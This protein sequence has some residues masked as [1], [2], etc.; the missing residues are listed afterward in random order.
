MERCSASG[1]NLV[2]DLLLMLGCVVLVYYVSRMRYRIVESSPASDRKC[3]LLD[4]VTLIVCVTS[5]TLV[6]F[7]LYNETQRH[8][9]LASHP[10]LNGSCYYSC[11]VPAILKTKLPPFAKN[12]LGRI[13]FVNSRRPSR[14]C[15]A[16][17]FRLPSLNGLLLEN[18][19]LEPS[20]LRSLSAIPHFRSLQ[21]NG[22]ELTIEHVS[23]IGQF[24][25]L[26]DL[27]LSYTN[28]DGNLLRS[29]DTL[30]RLRSV[31]FVGTPL[32]LADLGSPAWKDSVNLLE[33]PRQVKGPEDQLKIDQWS[34]LDLLS[35]SNPSVLVS[36]GTI[37]VEITN[38]PQL[39]RILID[40]VQKCDFIV[41]DLPKLQELGEELN[42]L[43]FFG[44]PLD[45]I[46]RESCFGIVDIENAPSLKELGVFANELKSI[47]IRNAPSL[48][49][50]TISNGQY[51]DRAGARFSLVHRDSLQR[52]IDD[53]GNCEGPTSLAFDRWDFQQINMQS[54]AKNQ[55][56][57][58]LRFSSSRI[59]FTQIRQLAGLFRL[60]SISA[61]SCK[62]SPDDLAWLLDTYPE[63][64][65]MDFD[66]GNIDK[67][68][69]CSQP[70][71]V[72]LKGRPLK[73]VR[74]IRIQDVPELEMDIHVACPVD[75]LLVSNAP[76]LTGL[77][78]ES[79]WPPQA[80]VSGLRGLKWFAAGGTGVDD[81]VL[82]SVL[83]CRS[84]DRLMPAYPS[85]SKESLRNIGDFS[86]LT[87]LVLPGAKVDD[88]VTSCYGKL[89]ML[90]EANFDYCK[91]GASTIEWLLRIESM[92]RLS[93][94]YVELP[95]EVLLVLSGMKQLNE[96][97]IAGAEVSEDVFTSL[98]MDLRLEHLNI[99]D[100]KLSRKKFEC[101]M[102]N[103]TLRLLNVCGCGLS[104]EQMQQLLGANPLLS[105]CS[106]E[107]ESEDT[108]EEASSDERASGQTP[109]KRLINSDRYRQIRLLLANY[110]ILQDA[111]IRDR[112][113]FDEAEP[114][115]DQA[116]FGWFE[117]S[118]F[119]PVAGMMET[120]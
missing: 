44:T 84:L 40:R 19:S 96:L 61:K 36:P 27:S 32:R 120:N 101:L 100:Q 112:Y 76:Q 119:R 113:Y 48:D 38:C 2:I 117:A 108:P 43:N 90:R 10:G 87:S 17:I 93:I 68:T 42:E 111:T 81:S 77:G 49:Q 24:H 118:K 92:R 64:E 69:L 83:Y 5:I 25:Q 1:K 115:M 20:Q 13:R 89:K 85:V 116:L 67:L 107:T 28:L 103:K 56:I 11:E 97:E 59:D 53:L 39:R 41:K 63:L 65:K 47:R 71:L 60:R 86:E 98:V 33:L 62:T 6:A 55:R 16:E 99:A 45:G 29:L 106:T 51:V 3:Q 80:K 37:R 8:L 94:N 52:I 88:T 91:I 57:R 109:T 75:E 105:I 30:K 12:F 54:L 58:E 70:N 50:L 18:V 114:N 79:P 21:L 82:D 102:Q 26:E 15:L 23:F 22:M 78:L 31:S 7:K 104:G 66:I 4:T 73:Q 95:P 14:E 74:S 9:R 72:S 110:G 34:A 46:A 35:I